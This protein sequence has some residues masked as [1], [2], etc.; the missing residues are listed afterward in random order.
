MG[1]SVTRILFH[2]A[3]DPKTPAK[4]RASE[5]RPVQLRD[6]GKEESFLEELLSE[7]PSLLALES[8]THG[9]HGPYATF[10]QVQLAAFGDVGGSIYPD[11]LV[12]CAS[13]HVVI[14]EAKLSD[15]HELKDRKA[16]GQVLEYAASISLLD[17]A[18]LARLLSDNPEGEQWASLIARHFPG[19]ADPEHLAECFATRVA[20]REL[21]LIVACDVAPPGTRELVA[22]VGAQSG[23]A[24]QLSLLE[25]HPHVRDDRPGEILF[26]PEIRVRTTIVARSSVVVDL[27]SD[28]RPKVSISAGDATEIAKAIEA[29]SSGAGRRSWD[30]KSFFDEVKQREPAFQDAL[31]RIYDWARQHASSI[32]WGTGAKSGSFSPRYPRSG[33]KSPFSVYT[34]GSLE[35]HPGWLNKNPAEDAV[36]AGLRKLASSLGVGVEGDE[37]HTRVPFESWKDKLPKVLEAL[38]AILR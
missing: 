10:R 24:F 37:S 21:I 7:S 32:K 25:V 13:G 26:A 28:G 20:S 38:D 30:Q 5:T 3:A 15:N 4:A 6:L 19:V 31:T 36:A 16:I 12:L 11:V 22:S 33:P 34:D 9:I 35:L 8:L 27:R 1:E 2:T 14:V 29:A 23:A 17:E 18:G